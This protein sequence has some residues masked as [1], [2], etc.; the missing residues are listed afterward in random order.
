MSDLILNKSDRKFSDAIVAL[1]G[2]AKIFD[3]T[4]TRIELFR[5]LDFALYPGDFVA[6]QGA[7]GAGKSTLLHIL[8]LLDQPSEGQV[9]FGGNLVSSLS[10]KALSAVRNRDIGFVFQFH[11]LLPDFTAYENILMPRR[12]AGVL[13]REDKL[14]VEELLSLIGLTARS[15]HLPAELSGGERQR[16]ALARALMNK[17]RLLLCDEPSG[18]LDAKNSESLHGILAELN[19]NMNV[20]ILVVT[21]DEHLAQTAKTVYTLLDGA[22]H[23]KIMSNVRSS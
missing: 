16:I 1:Q 23:L 8:G 20:T 10:D 14:R 6:I 9:F 11:H 21:H 7:S 2:A 5:E 15:K 19:G 3:E 4:G 18:N 13:Q 22:L 12:I 17:P